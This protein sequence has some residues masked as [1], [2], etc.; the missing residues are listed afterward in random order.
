MIAPYLSF[1]IYSLT[2][3]PQNAYVTELGVDPSPLMAVDLMHDF[4]LG[5]GRATTLHILRLLLAEGNGRIEEFDARSVLYALA[6]PFPDDV[7]LSASPNVW[8]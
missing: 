8:Q 3:H 7:Q 1:W 5:V 4:E 6:K 2:P